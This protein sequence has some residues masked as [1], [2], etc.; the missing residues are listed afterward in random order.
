MPTVSASFSPEITSPF[1]RAGVPV[2]GSI[3]TFATSFNTSQAA[4]VRSKLPEN[5]GMINFLIVGINWFKLN[6][7]T[8][9]PKTIPEA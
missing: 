3:T 9:I 4:V 6:N 8:G 1:V 2:P 7:F 5:T